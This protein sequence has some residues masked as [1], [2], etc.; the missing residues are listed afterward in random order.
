MLSSTHV[1]LTAHY[2]A[3]GNWYVR[4][5][6][7]AKQKRNENWRK[8]ARRDPGVGPY[9]TPTASTNA[10]RPCRTAHAI[11]HDRM[12][13][14]S[15]WALF[16]SNRPRT[17]ASPPHPLPDEYHS[18]KGSRRRLRRQRNA[19]QHRSSTAVEWV[20][21]CGNSYVMRDTSTR[22]I[23]LWELISESLTRTA[24]RTR[25]PRKT[26]DQSMRAPTVS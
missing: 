23:R 5:L 25:A 3:Q 20:L 16:R 1:P 15:T 12:G 7:H 2:T 22:P 14:D 24:P 19:P 26:R 9:N 18:F 6:D 21:T 11:T 8:E 17:A 13:A 4:N 10:P